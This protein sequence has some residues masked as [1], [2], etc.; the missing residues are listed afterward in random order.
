MEYMKTR[1]SFRYPEEAYC[2][3]GEGFLRLLGSKVY[4]SFTCLYCGKEFYSLNGVQTHMANAGHQRV[5]MLY[6]EQLLEY[7]PY[8]D[9][10]TSFR[11][12]KLPPHV[13]TELELMLNEQEWE[14]IDDVLLN[15]DDWDTPHA[16]STPVD[17]PSSSSSLEPHN[18]TSK[19]SSALL[20]QYAPKILPNGD[21]HITLT[22]N[23][24]ANKRRL[25]H[26]PYRFAGTT[27]SP[28]P[29]AKVFK[30]TN[31]EAQPLTKEQHRA[32]KRYLMHAVNRRRKEL[33]LAHTSHTLLDRHTC[34]A[35]PPPPR[36]KKMV[37]CSA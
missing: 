29:P 25:G 36:P 5:G 14:L 31:H 18:K 21:L 17:A 11:E 37:A 26:K 27:I 23:Q 19:N 6:E 32:A 10:T 24:L 20:R 28:K 33:G 9:Y 22:G 1:F 35:P 16:P 2:F 8:Y 3:D 30:I 12:I 4:S 13:L 7:A 15:D 34:V